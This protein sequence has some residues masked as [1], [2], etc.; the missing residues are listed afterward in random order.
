[1]KTLQPTRSQSMLTASAAVGH[2]AVALPS[3]LQ[4]V[5]VMVAAKMMMVVVEVVVKVVVVVM[6]VVAVLGRGGGGDKHNDDDDGEAWALHLT[7]TQP[8]PLGYLI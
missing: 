8:P 4:V 6:V 5:V 7:H 3:D 2:F 1:M